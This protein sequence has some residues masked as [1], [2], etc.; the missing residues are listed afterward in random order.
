ME[1]SGLFRVKCRHDVGMRQPRG[2]AEL[3]MEAFDGGAV[4]QE[5]G[6]DDFER[7]EAIHQSML[8]FVDCTHSAAAEES[9]HAVPRMIDQ[10]WRDV[11]GIWRNGLRLAIDMQA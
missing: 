6:A 8:G 1:V 2:G 11:G 9:Q 7:H 10:F 4:L 5:R 3:A